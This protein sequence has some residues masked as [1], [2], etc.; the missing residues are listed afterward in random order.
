M[1]AIATGAGKR[2]RYGEET[3]GAPPAA[4]SGK[5]LRRV[6][7][8]FKLDRAV[9]QSKEVRTDKQRAAS[10][11]GSKSVTGTLSGELSCGSYGDFLAAALRGD[12]AVGA[13]TGSLTT[14]SSNAG[15]KVLTRTGGSFVTDGFKLGDY[16]EGTGAIVCS[17]TLT[18]VAAT[19]M[20]VDGTV[21]T[22]A[23]GSATT[24]TVVGKKAMVPATG[25]TS[26]TFYV[27]EFYEEIARYRKITGLVV[28]GFSL[29]IQ[30]DN[31]AT[32]S[33][34]MVGK[35]LTPDSAQY[36]TA[37]T[38]A[39]TT[40]PLASAASAIY[41]DGVAPGVI[42]SLKMDVSVGA[43]PGKVVGANVAPAVFVNTVDISGSIGM[44]F[45]DDSFL[46]KSVAE[47]PI[48]LWIRLDDG[49][50][51]SIT[52]KLLEVKLGNV[53]TTDV[54]DGL[55]VTAD[56]LPNKYTGASTVTEA[57]TIVLQDTTL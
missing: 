20:T 52:L 9:I 41:I 39:L 22:V 53:D 25:H 51:E 34:K 47:T 28:D 12:W 21:P 1:P 24:I 16:I 46:T 45:S 29:D 32:I 35:D 13:T 42:T 33:F 38:A 10:R 56:L 18:S 43:K 31:L 3:A 4:G 44:F 11:F 2:L 17:G 8:N 7:S 49:T 19:T 40:P 23:A 6:S 14:I 15:T 27:E 26:K 5:T 48:S 57:S 37:A 30:P 36:F 55:V 50:G 54:E